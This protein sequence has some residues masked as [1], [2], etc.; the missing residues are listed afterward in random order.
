MDKKKTVLPFHSTKKLQ[1]HQYIVHT[2][3]FC[4]QLFLTLCLAAISLSPVVKTL[5]GLTFL[6]EGKP[7]KTLEAFQKTATQALYMKIKCSM[8]KQPKNY[9]FF[10]HRFVISKA[11]LFI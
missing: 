1:S 9:L 6:Y 11:N 10:F 8:E 7:H 2:N 4:Q 3:H 5:G